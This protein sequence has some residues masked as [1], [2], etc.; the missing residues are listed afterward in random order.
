M[1]GRNCKKVIKGFKAGSYPV[2]HKCVYQVDVYDAVHWVCTGEHVATGKRCTYFDTSSI[3]FR[4]CDQRDK[5]AF[6]KICGDQE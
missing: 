6:K 1:F 5:L 2:C 4:L 3:H